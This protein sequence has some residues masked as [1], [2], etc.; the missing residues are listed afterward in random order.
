MCCDIGPQV[1]RIELSNDC[2]R[3][4]LRDILDGF[5]GLEEVTLVLCDI[6]SRGLHEI[7]I[8]EPEKKSVYEQYCTVWKTAIQDSMPPG[9]QSHIRAMDFETALECA[10][11][12]DDD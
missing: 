3:C 10:N 4:C 1:R 11:E 5:P 8:T 12:D 7:A 6:F 9:V 2:T